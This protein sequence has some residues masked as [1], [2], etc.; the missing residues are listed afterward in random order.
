M[1]VQRHRLED[2]RASYLQL[3]V[4]ARGERK[5]RLAAPLRSLRVFVANM[6]IAA[7]GYLH[8]QPAAEP[9]DTA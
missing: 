5:N 9:I 8:Q 2:T 3:Q 7:G 1:D 4:A 6:L